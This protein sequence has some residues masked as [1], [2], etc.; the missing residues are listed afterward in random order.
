[1][2]LL[3]IFGAGAV[4]GFL[5]GKGTEKLTGLLWGAAALGGVYVLISRK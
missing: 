4:A 5:A 1:M 2:P 3:L